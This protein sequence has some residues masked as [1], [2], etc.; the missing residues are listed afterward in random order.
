MLLSS[1]AWPWA[2]GGVIRLEAGEWRPWASPQTLLAVL[3]LVVKVMPVMV[4]R[5]D[6]VAVRTVPFQFTRGSEP[7]LGEAVRDIREES[8]AL[9]ELLP[10][11]SEVAELPPVF[12]RALRD[13]PLPCSRFE[14]A[15]AAKTCSTRCGR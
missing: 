2:G 10:A 7:A 13:V 6:R 3:A 11:L 8:D 5:S 12:A 14:P 1:G 4:A 15:I 9:P